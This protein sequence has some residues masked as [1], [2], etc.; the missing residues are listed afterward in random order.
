MSNYTVNTENMVELNKKTLEEWVKLANEY[1]SMMEGE[2]KI[3]EIVFYSRLCFDAF[4]YKYKI[5][6]EVSKNI[7]GHTGID[8]LYR[9]LP[10][11]VYKKR[12][13]NFDLKPDQVAFVYSDLTYKIERWI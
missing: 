5:T 11:M 1:K 7:N 6:T 13:Y 8:S 10:V 3:K 12:N 4:I 2:V 9:G